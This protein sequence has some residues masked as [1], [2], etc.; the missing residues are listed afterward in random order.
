MRCAMQRTL[1]FGRTVMLLASIW[2]VANPGLCNAGPAPALGEFML[3]QVKPSKGAPFFKLGPVTLA[4][5]LYGT[6][7]YV[8]RSPVVLGAPAHQIGQG[9]TDPNTHLTAYAVKS[10]K[11]SLPFVPRS[12]VRV[13]NGC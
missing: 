13:D 12:D 5:P 6:R 1:T 7:D 10:A 9:F 4:D 8:L 3:Y 2:I 11:G